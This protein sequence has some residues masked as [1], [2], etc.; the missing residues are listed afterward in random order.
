MLESEVSPGPG[1]RGDLSLQHLTWDGERTVTDG[2]AHSVRLGLLLRSPGGVRLFGNQTRLGPWAASLLVTS[3]QVRL[4]ITTDQSHGL[5]LG[6]L[7][8]ISF[9][10]FVSSPGQSSVSTVLPILVPGLRSRSLSLCLRVLTAA[11]TCQEVAVERRESGHLHHSYSS[12]TSDVQ[13]IPVMWHLDSQPV[14]R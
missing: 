1:T 8:N 10:F 7:Q 11:Q 4:N 9:S 5:I 6:R 13:P 14:T 2:G 3:S 12:H